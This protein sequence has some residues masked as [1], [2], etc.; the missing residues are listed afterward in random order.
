MLAAFFPHLCPPGLAH[1]IMP[2]PWGPL[3]SPLCPGWLALPL[4]PLPLQASHG[5]SCWEGCSLSI[6]QMPGCLEQHLALGGAEGARQGPWVHRAG[7]RVQPWAAS[8]SSV[9][10]R[11]V[12]RFQPPQTGKT[13]ACCFFPRSHLTA[14][15]SLGEQLFMMIFSDIFGAVSACQASHDE[16]GMRY[17]VQA[18]QSLVKGVLLFAHFMD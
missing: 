12:G 18:S 9:L 14:H 1:F 10:P 7:G 5:G 4:L 17:S 16:L 6:S 3:P 13:C 8:G 11:P 2:G 15:L